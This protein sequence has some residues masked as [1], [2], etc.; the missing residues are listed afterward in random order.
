MCDLHSKFEED[1]TKTAIAIVDD[2]YFEQTVTQTDRQTYTQVSLYLS[3]A[4]HCIVQTII[5][6][7]IIIITVR[8]T[9][10][11]VATWVIVLAVVVGVGALAAT[12]GLGVHL[13]R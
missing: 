6:I 9:V 7:T 10:V 4:M 5:V 11:V 12:T 2:R 13:F 8:Q 3:N 1:L